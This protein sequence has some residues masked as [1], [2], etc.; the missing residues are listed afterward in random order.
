MNIVL[1]LNRDLEANL[2][3]NLLKE[4]LLKH[5]VRIYYTDSVG[6][7]DNKP[8]E[9]A[10]LEYLEKRYVYDQLAA[11]LSRS[12][13]NTSFELFDDHF[14]SFPLEKARYVNS[15]EFIA[16]MRDF[17]PDLFISIRFGKI[18]KD[19]IISVPTY[20]L[21]NLHS[22]ILPD[23]RGVLGTLH[24]LKDGNQEIGCTLHTIPNGD[25]DTGE[26]IEIARLE[27]NPQRSL[28][29]HVV[30]LYPMGVQLIQKA[31]KQIE[32]KGSLQTQPQDLRAGNYYSV[33]TASDFVALQKQG[34]EVISMQDYQQILTEMIF[35]DVTEK[36]KRFLEEEI[37]KV[38]LM[39]VK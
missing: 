7:D 22:A 32:E 9:L 31:L 30:N 37:E 12:R 2:A 26:I 13:I 34:I 25:I 16:Q 11:F 39:I 33:P 6:K 21:I 1:F 20:G 38:F 27:V 18:F 29:W 28:F 15:A 8:A 14:S 5:T 35:K 36:E 23:Y 17:Q 4:E 24:A 3:Y 10:Q 19:G